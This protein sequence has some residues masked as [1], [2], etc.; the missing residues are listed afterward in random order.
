MQA[1]QKATSTNYDATVV[2]PAFFE[3]GRITLN[4]EQ[5]IIDGQSLVPLSSTHFAD[6]EQFPFRTSNLVEWVKHKTRASESYRGA[7]SDVFEGSRSETRI[8]TQQLQHK[9]VEEPKVVSI[10]LQEIRE[11]G[12]FF[13]ANKLESL[14]YGAVV[15]VNG[16]WYVRGLCLYMRVRIRVY[17]VYA[18][19]VQL[20]EYWILLGYAIYM[21]L[22]SYILSLSY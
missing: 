13:V 6:D 19:V 10:S 15:V 2:C 21:S 16:R 7:D 11:G 20:I 12:P 1:I 14:P 9:E 3:G 17:L 22:Y 5:Y 8:G 18:S 4:D